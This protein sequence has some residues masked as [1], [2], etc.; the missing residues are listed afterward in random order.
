[1]ITFACPRCRTEYRYSDD[2][3]GKKIRCA[4]PNCCQKLRIPSSSMSTVINAPPAPG[5]TPAPDRGAAHM[6]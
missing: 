3:A 2:M 1:M 5:N 4:G 6:P